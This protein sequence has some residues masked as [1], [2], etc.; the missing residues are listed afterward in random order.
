MSLFAQAQ[1]SQQPFFVWYAP[2]LPHA[3]HNPPDR[4]LDLYRDQ[5]PTLPIAKYWAMCHW[6]DET[7]GELLQFLD[8]NQLR[9]NTLVVY[10]TDNGWIN[11]AD[12]SAYAPRSKRSPYEGGLRTPMMIRY[13]AV[14]APRMDDRAVVSSLDLAP[15]V[16]HA[17]GL[18]PTAEMSGINLL[19]DAAVTAR[20]AVYGEIFEHD[21][22]DCDLPAQSLRYRWVIEMP[23]KLIVPHPSASAEPAAAAVRPAGGSVRTDRPRRPQPSHREPPA[24]AV[25]RVV[26][27]LRQFFSD[28]GKNLRAE[29]P[30][31]TIRLRGMPV[32]HD[33]FQSGKQRREK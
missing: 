7:C 8:D 21:I 18:Q 32:W 17:C 4:L 15:T 16:L 9:E 33:C 19:D 12:R 20:A 31:L 2:F 3:P 5:A 11:L 30:A 27:S 10:V 29:R 26:D 24:A 1:A 14:V 23:W 28:P 22:V 13:P 25:G 6:F